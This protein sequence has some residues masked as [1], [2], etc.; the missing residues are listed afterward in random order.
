MDIRICGFNNPIISPVP[1]STPAWA[2]EAMESADPLRWVSD[3][4]APWEDGLFSFSESF[5]RV[6]FFHGE[7]GWEH[8]FQSFGFDVGRDRYIFTSGGLAAMVED[9][10]DYC[11]VYVSYDRKYI[12][13]DEI[14]DYGIYVGPAQDLDSCGDCGRRIFD[15]LVEEGFYPYPRGKN[16]M[17]WR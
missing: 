2:G 16:K 15:A 8:P 13:A 3:N 12:Y 4:V 14:P 7:D 6:V 1:M 5:P 9:G 17:L 11:S 10:E